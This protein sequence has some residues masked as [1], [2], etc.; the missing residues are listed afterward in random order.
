MNKCAKTNSKAPA[1]GIAIGK[2]LFKIVWPLEDKYSFIPIHDGLNIY[3][4]VHIALYRHP[5]V[6]L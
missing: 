1:N 3:K 6:G 4:Y 5:N 2:E